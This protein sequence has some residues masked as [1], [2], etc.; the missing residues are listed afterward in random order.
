MQTTCADAQGGLDS[1]VAGVAS[2][3]VVIEL[4]DFDHEITRAVPPVLASAWPGYTLTPRGS[5][6]LLDAIA[7]GAAATREYLAAH[8]VKK[9]VLVIITDGNE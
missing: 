8:A 2:D 4:I 6:A 9:S 3:D 7:T 5:T 1:F